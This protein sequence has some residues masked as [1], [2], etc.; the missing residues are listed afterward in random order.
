ML[1]L[2]L[3]RRGVFDGWFR[4]W[5]RWLGSV[6]LGKF[7]LGLG[8][9][10]VFDDWRWL[11]SGFGLWFFRLGLDDERAPGLRGGSLNDGSGVPAAG[12]RVGKW[13]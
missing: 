2:G 4:F 6:E 5:G 12:D 9:S 7:R 1:R 10:D 3:G 13:R 11:R 8:R